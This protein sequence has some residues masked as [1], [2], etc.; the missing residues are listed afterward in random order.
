MSVSR[1]NAMAAND[2]AEKKRMQMEKARQLKEERK[3]N[4][5]RVAED[6]IVGGGGGGPVGR[7]S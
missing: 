5:M 7:Q 3:H 1:K 2:Y 4:I 6:Q